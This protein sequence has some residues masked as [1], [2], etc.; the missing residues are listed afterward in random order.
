MPKWQCTHDG[1]SLTITRQIHDMQSPPTS[2]CSSCTVLF[3]GV[4]VLREN[5]KMLHDTV[6]PRSR[7]A[8]QYH[9]VTLSECVMRQRNACAG[10]FDRHSAMSDGDPTYEH[11]MPHRL[12]ISQNALL[13]QNTINSGTLLHVSREAQG[14]KGAPVG[15]TSPEKVRLFSTV[16]E[17]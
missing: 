9:W 10:I 17:S 3:G 6:K 7:T 8:L 5:V 2:Q 4:Q 12:L 14:R 13:T 1:V 11:Q 15:S 16:K